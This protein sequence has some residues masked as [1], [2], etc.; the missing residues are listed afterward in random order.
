[1]I[2]DCF[3]VFAKVGD[4]IAFSRGN[5]GAKQFEEAIITKITAKS[6]YF[7]GKTGSIYRSESDELR[8]GEGCFVINVSKREAIALKELVDLSE[9]DKEQ[10]RVFSR[11]Q[12]MEYL[13][14]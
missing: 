11:D 12:L 4:H 10:G 2:A 1:M 13:N 9:K 14:D 5:A 6:I 3:G 7:S 8:R